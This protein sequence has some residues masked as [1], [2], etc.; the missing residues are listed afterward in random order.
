MKSLA[1]EISPCPL[2]V[3]TI[4]AGMDSVTSG[5]KALDK[6]MT[7]IDQE[8][9]ELRSDIRTLVEGALKRFEW[10]KVQELKKDQL[11]MI[12]LLQVE[13]DLRDEFHLCLGSYC[14][15]LRKLRDEATALRDQAAGEVITQIISSVGLPEDAR[16]QPAIGAVAATHPQVRQANAKIGDIEQSAQLVDDSDFNGP[17]GANQDRINELIEAILEE[18]KAVLKAENLEGLVLYCYQRGLECEKLVNPGDR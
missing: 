7:A 15:A 10:K 16:S 2:P 5:R 8:R 1:L 14:D 13:R 3:V 17:W 18:S 4:R 9:E 6:R 11:R 12:E